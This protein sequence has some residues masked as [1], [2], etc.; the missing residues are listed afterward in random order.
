[1][2]KMKDTAPANAPR[3]CFV[4]PTYNE[5][6]NVPSLLA[7]LAQEY[8]GEGTRF[9]IVDD[10]SPDGTADRVREFQARDSRVHLLEGKRRGLGDAYVRGISHALDSLEAE[11]V[12]QMDADFS[13]DPADARKLLARVAHGADAAIGSR[14]V[15]GG[16]VDE[17][18][19]P[20]R[21]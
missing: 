10:E 8:E 20:A 16:S 13:H 15:S 3:V 18:W 19:S 6:S 7:R 17:E 5:A 11:V 9:L 21:R 4:I 2:H 14:Y 12:V 1:M